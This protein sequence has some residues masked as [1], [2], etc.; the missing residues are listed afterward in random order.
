ML[1]PFPGGIIRDWRADDAEPLARHANN[2][3]VW[4]NLRDRFPSPYTF[5]D[6]EGWLRHC[7]RV[8]PAV[9]FAIEVG[10][11][12]SGGIGVELGSDVERVGAEVGY[13]LGQ[14]CWGRGVMSGAVQA[15]A[16]WALDRYNLARLYARV[17][18]FNVASARV[19]EK[20]GFALEGRLKH[21][22]FKNGALID[23]LLY[24]RTRERWP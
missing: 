17:F 13:W 9:D 23:Q 10:G 1:L 14:S 22:A 7:A 2:R 3:R 15:F 21:S 16:P 4:E 11:E 6:A 20:A 19:L 5:D 12:A 18:A 24:A 8:V